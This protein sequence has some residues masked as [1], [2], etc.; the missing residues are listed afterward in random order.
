ML[1]PRTQLLRVK[2][3]PSEMKELTEKAHKRGLNLSD[4]VRSILFHA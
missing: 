4:H 1:E 2:L 3:R